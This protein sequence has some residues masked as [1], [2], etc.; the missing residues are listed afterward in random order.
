M[1]ADAPLAVLK[2]LLA[3]HSSPVFIIDVKAIVERAIT[4][5]ASH[6]A[7]STEVAAHYASRLVAFFVG[8]VF[9]RQ[10]HVDRSCATIKPAL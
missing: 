8:F 7:I 2:T 9:V 10:N 4:G 6:W 1:S 5:V 3:N